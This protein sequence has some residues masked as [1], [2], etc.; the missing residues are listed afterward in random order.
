MNNWFFAYILIRCLLEALGYLPN[1]LVTGPEGAI[2]IFRIFCFALNRP[3]LKFL[4]IFAFVIFCSE[5]KPLSHKVT[6][7]VLL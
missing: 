6:P 2:A 5:V 4:R 1:G 3:L 7:N